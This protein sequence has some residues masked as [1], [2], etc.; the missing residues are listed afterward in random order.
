MSSFVSIKKTLLSIFVFVFVVY[1][2]SASPT[3]QDKST[4]PKERVWEI[5]ERGKTYPD[6]LWELKDAP[7]DLVYGPLT[8][9]WMIHR[10]AVRDRSDM[11]K[12]GREAEYLADQ[13]RVGR[14]PEY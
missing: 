12:K 5:A 11:K 13:A 6:A 9:F 14:D 7:L 8:S 3:E 10:A 1:T 2:G 4:W